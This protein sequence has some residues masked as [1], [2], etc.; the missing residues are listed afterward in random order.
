MEEVRQKK[1]EKHIN[2]VVIEGRVCGPAEVQVLQSGERISVRIASHSDYRDKKEDR[3]VDVTNFVNIIAR[4]SPIG[5]ILRNART[6]DVITVQGA[7]VQESWVDRATNT[8]RERYYVDPIMLR[9]PP[10]PQSV[11][12]QRE[13][14]GNVAG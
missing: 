8:N 10:R 7:L 12:Q 11:E 1:L 6:G 13:A 9:Y 5:D 3:V 4:K 14:D 2:V